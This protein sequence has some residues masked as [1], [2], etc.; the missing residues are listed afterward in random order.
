MSQIKPVVNGD[1][2]FSIDTK[3]ARVGDM[4][5]VQINITRLNGK[6]KDTVTATYQRI[7]IVKPIVA[8]KAKK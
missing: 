7:K 4:F 2:T 6:D 3:D 5:D 8:K 1:F